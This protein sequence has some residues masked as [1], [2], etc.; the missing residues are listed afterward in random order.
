MSRGHLHGPDAAS[1]ARLRALRG[2]LRRERER[3][4][5]EAISIGPC[6]RLARALDELERRERDL[7]R[8]QRRRREA[9]PSVRRFIVAFL[10]PSARVH[11]G[12]P[13]RDEAEAGRGA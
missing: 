6:P 13:Y 11:E 3:I 10:H 7:A 1:R 9:R 12:A 4:E 5:A 8:A 2:E